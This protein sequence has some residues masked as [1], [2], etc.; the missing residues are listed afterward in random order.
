MSFRIKDICRKDHNIDVEQGHVLFVVGKNG[1]GKS[2]LVMGWA[3]SRPDH[4]VLT[5]NREVSFVNSAVSLSP[6]QM[7]THEGYGQTNLRSHDSRTSRAFHNSQDWLKTLVARL[8]VFEKHCMHQEVSAHREG[9]ADDAKKAQE[10]NPFIQ[11]NQVFHSIGLPLSLSLDEK[12]NFKVAKEG[13][14]DSYGIDELSDGE[15]A[16]LVLIS[17]VILADHGQ[18]I[19]I[20]EPERHMHRSV[21]SPLLREMFR[22]RPDLTWIVATHDVSLLRDFS[23]AKLL[24]LYGYNGFG[25]QFDMLESTRNL[26]DE[27]VDAIYGAREKVLFVEGKQQR[28]LDEPLYQ[29]LFPDTTIKS[30]GSCNEVQRSVEALNSV[31]A[32]NSMT[33]RGLVDADNRN[34]AASLGEAGISKLGVYAVESLYFHSSVIE[35]LAAQQDK[36][37]ELDQILNMACSEVSDE[38]LQTC[39][40]N[41]AERALRAH[42]RGNPPRYTDLSE[43]NG[44]FKIDMAPFKAI[45]EELLQDMRAAL[46]EN[47]WN[48]L[49][50]FVKIKGT[51]AP[52]RIREA[53]GLTQ[54]GYSEQARR[55]LASNDDVRVII[56]DLA[57]N[58]F[59]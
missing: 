33:A 17:A 25:W 19:T 48:E 34:D 43:N 50:K 8:D 26:P 38:F 5:G 59:A 22:R 44:T 52:K 1:S 10:R 36:S 58:P 6:S 54:N 53:L 40:R 49:V 45:E 46:S 28:S 9:N 3:R 37:A 55:V 12:A 13:V 30:R 42:L 41:C 23:D 51:H 7:Q 4:P 21:S 47:N 15:R 27:V 20:D 31:G 56:S 32:L 11:I 24:V 29:V 16:A 35:A 18:T 57:P 39:A 2:T 14:A